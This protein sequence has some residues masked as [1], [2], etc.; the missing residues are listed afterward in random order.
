[1]VAKIVNSLE[2]DVLVVFGATLVGGEEGVHVGPYS[3]G[4]RFMG[5]EQ[6]FSLRLVVA[7]V[8]VAIAAPAFCQIF[9]AS[10]ILCL[11]RISSTA[12]NAFTKMTQQIE[13]IEKNL[14]KSIEHGLVRHTFH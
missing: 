1:M 4:R 14:P 5:V 13:L 10:S 12:T 11:I 2:D 3:T 8:G 7:A 6:Y 9:L